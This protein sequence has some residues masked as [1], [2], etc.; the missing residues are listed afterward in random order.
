MR[1]F[2][3]PWGPPVLTLEKLG[4]AYRPNIYCEFMSHTMPILEI[5][6]YTKSLSD[7]STLSGFLRYL[8]QK[9]SDN[10]EFFIQ[11]HKKKSTHNDEN[12][13]I[14]WIFSNIWKLNDFYYMDGPKV[15][16]WLNLLR[17]YLH[18]TLTSLI[19]VEF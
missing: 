16:C 15:S 6:K 11:I 1:L 12:Q 7:C 10:F 3:S 17:V 4:R 14:T 5:G 13:I 19:S 18:L 9:I 8:Y 2:L